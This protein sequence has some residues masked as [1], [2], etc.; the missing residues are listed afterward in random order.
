MASRSCPGIYARTRR[1][2]PNG[3]Q[4]RAAHYRNICYLARVR[5]D[6][7]RLLRFHDTLGLSPNAL[8][9]ATLTTFHSC[10]PVYLLAY[11]L[12]VRTI[13]YIVNACVASNSVPE[14]CWWWNIAVATAF[15]P[16]QRE[17]VLTL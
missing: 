7:G 17:G 13:V 11:T 6:V 3:I 4:R 14:A 5:C 12:V 10:V 16:Q 1:R 15:D 9:A 8:Q 2:T